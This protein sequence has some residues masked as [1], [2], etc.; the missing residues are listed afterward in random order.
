MCACARKFLVEFA[1]FENEERKNGGERKTNCVFSCC[2][3][4]VMQVKDFTYFAIRGVHILC[5]LLNVCA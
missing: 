4:S 1:V 3:H 2:L 5:Y